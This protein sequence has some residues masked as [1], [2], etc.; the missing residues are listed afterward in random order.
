MADPKQPSERRAVAR[1][2][3]EAQIHLDEG[4]FCEALAA[5]NS[6]P[7][8]ENHPGRLNTLAEILEA[9][10]MWEPLCEVRRRLLK[11]DED[12][13]DHWLD[14]ARAVENAESAA[15]ALL[16]L[17]EGEGRIC[18]NMEYQY[19]LCRLVCACGSRKEALAEAVK[20]NRFGHSFE[21]TSQADEDYLL[22]WRADPDA[23]AWR[24]SVID[25]P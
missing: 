14:L 8:I 11:F 3:L 18:H 2:I 19:E 15:A 17:R 13:P 5:I 9:A 24:E 25:P 23:V 6:E 16:I 12:F 1:V 22:A 4:R 21:L 7:T 10:R 20:L